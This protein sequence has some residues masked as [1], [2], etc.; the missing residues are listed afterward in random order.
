MC[1]G[2][3]PGRCAT[4][5]M[6]GRSVAYFAD[7]M[8]IAPSSLHQTFLYLTSLVWSRSR[9]PVPRL[10][11]PLVPPVSPCLV[12]SY[13]RAA[14][15]VLRWRE[16]FTK[17]GQS[18]ERYQFYSKAK[19]FAQFDAMTKETFLSGVTG[20]QRPKAVPGDLQFDAARGILTFLDADTPPAGTAGDDEAG[21]GDSSADAVDGV[22][23][24]PLDDGG[25]SSE[26][27]TPDG[28]GHSDD[29]TPDGMGSVPS[30]PPQTAGFGRYMRRRSALRAATAFVR[31]GLTSK[32][33]AVLTAGIKAKSAY[34]DVPDVLMMASVLRHDGVHV[35]KSLEEARR[36]PQWPQWLQALKE[37]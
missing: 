4:L 37:E 3:L 35:P 34:V 25:V 5:P 19:T 36:S 26:D 27:N 18:G 9:R 21:L 33:R 15:M 29:D 23:G 2:P 1:D 28:I 24:S 17:T 13:T 12:S 6:H 20:T 10:V 11:L 32:E 16:G 7:Q 31:K 30:P 22:A 14:G 8:G